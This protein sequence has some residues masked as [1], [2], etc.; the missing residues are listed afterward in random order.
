MVGN[1]CPVC[2]GAYLK[3]VKVVPAAGGYGVDCPACGPFALS[4]E[5]WE[6]FL[7]LKSGPGSK[8]TAVQRARLSHRLRRAHAA[9]ERRPKMDS[10]FVERFITDGCPGPTPAEQVERLIELVGDYVSKSG[11]RLKQLPDDTYSL[12]GSAN[13]TLAGELAIEL[14]K[15][16]V[17]DGDPYQSS[18]T[19]QTL[20]RVSLTLDGWE[21]YEAGKRGQFSGSVG[22]IAMKFGDSV[23]DKFVEDV[24]K[25]AVRNGIGYDLVHMRDVSRAGVIDNL[26]RAQIRDSAFI[27]IDLTHDNSG[28]YWEAGYAEGLDKPVIYIC[29]Q[30]KFDAVKTHF[31][32]N[33]CTTVMWS[34]DRADEF[35]AELIATLRRSLNLFPNAG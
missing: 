2:L 19:Q 20:R 22:F 13:P 27:I 32:T 33:H 4:E 9:G 25:P 26:M 18:T 17:L 29:E 1:Y 21:K 6:D 12:I 24:I 5:A 14:Y 7:D 11:E 34:I 23:L 31:D 35:A 8:L 28:A 16:D 3:P 30:G 10:E 15:R